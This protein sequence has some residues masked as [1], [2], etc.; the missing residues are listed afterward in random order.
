ME[1]IN[2]Q[3]E[4]IKNQDVQSGRFELYINEIGLSKT[5]VE[6]LF[7]EGKGFARVSEMPTD[8]VSE[9]DE[10]SERVRDVVY[11]LDGISSELSG[12]SVRSGSVAESLSTF[13]Q[14]MTWSQNPITEKSAIYLLTKPVEDL[15]SRHYMASLAGMAHYYNSMPN[16]SREDLLQADQNWYAQ[17]KTRFAQIET[18]KKSF[19][20]KK[21]TPEKQQ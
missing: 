2:K 20:N 11:S 5:S 13:S 4:N 1:N 12:V 10:L 18:A 19:E 3:I 6:M 9:I 8:L 16:V 7:A 17:M 21:I 14:N 15:V